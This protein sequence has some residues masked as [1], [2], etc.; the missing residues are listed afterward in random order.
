MIFFILTICMLG[1]RW[2]QTKKFF[3]NMNR[4]DAVDIFSLTPRQQQNRNLINLR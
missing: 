2:K 1:L 3:I 4:N